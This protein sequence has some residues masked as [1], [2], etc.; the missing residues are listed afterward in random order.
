M[1]LVDADYKFIIV[2]VGDLGK[3]SDGGIF[4]RSELGKKYTFSKTLIS[5][6]RSNAL[7]HS[8]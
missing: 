5:N 7:C 8:R 1:A 3:N 2:N 6:K 4:S